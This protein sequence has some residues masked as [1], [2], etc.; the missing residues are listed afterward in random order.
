MTDNEFDDYAS[1]RYN[2]QCRWYDDK[3]GFNKRWYY[4]L[5]TTVIVVSAAITLAVAIGVYFE[6]VRWI[7][8]VA[9]ALGASVTVF[10]SL[11]KIYRFQEQ[12]LSY[13][14]TAEALKKEAHLLMARLGE[15]GASASPRELFVDRVENLVSR[16]NTQWMG[17]AVEDT[18]S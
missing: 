17:R 5:Q 1:N 2:E 18:G 3:A 11:L 15:Y 8:L 10:T 16:Q 13:R 6:D 9:L 4:R 14:G 12:W 7:R